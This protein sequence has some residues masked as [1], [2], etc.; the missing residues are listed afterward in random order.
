MNTA[1]VHQHLPRAGIDPIDSAET[2]LEM[3]ATAIHRPVRDETIVLVLDAERRGVAIA[4]VSGTRRPDD[5]V[6]VVECLTRAGTH[7]GRM[8]AIV[9]ASVRSTVETSDADI[10]RWLEM[11]D[12]A[13]QAG[14]ELVEWFVID[15]RVT[16]P[17]D[18]LGEPPRW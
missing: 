14:V 4:V 12:I 2:A 5:V 8:G 3:L 15:R 13:E 18:E 6:E 9:V 16:C 11:S 10:D 7:G 1:P 17:R